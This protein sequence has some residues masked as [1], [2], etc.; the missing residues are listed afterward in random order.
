MAHNI[1]RC[2][3]SFAEVALLGILA[4][5]AI[6]ACTSQDSPPAP[7]EMPYPGQPPDTAETPPRDESSPSDSAAALEPTTWTTIRPG[8]TIVDLAFTDNAELTLQ[9]QV[10]LP[11][12]PVTYN[13]D[14]S[15]TPST[16]AERLIVSPTSPSGRYT[17]VKAC[18]DPNPG[19]GLCWAAYIID[20]D[21][22][23]A[24]RISIGKYGGQDWLQWSPDERYAVFIETMEGTSWFVVLDLEIGESLVME[25]LPAEPTLSEMTWESDRT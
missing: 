10:L 1:P 2:L 11:E 20:R 3:R 16:Y 13:S 7:Q 9:D 25:E 18:D 6:A 5:G 22:P 15:G 17:I 4:G 8:E 23:L 24:Q 14:D 21:E 12:I 19:M